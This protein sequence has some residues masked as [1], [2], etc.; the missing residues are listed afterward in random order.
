MTAQRTPGLVRG[1]SSGA[2]AYL[3]WG[4]F[5]IIITALSFANAWEVIA[6]RVIFGFVFGVIFVLA[7][8]NGREIFQALKSRKTFLLIIVST[9]MIYINWSVYV[10]A[11][12]TKHTVDASLGYF[13]NPLFTI[14]IA[15]LFLKE[16]LSRLQVVAVA[17][18]LV[19]VSILTVNYGAPPWLA[20]ALAASFSIYGYAKNQLSGSISSLNGYVVESGILVPV[21]GLQLIILAGQPGS[22]LS[23]G[24]A[25]LWETLGLVGF[26][27]LTAI[28]LILFGEAAKHLPLSWVGL[29]QYLTPTLQFIVAVLILGEPMSLP[30]WIGF[31]FVWIALFVLTIDASRK[32]KSRT[33]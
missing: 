27:F 10:F 23:F 32:F 8:R 31:A 30:R 15:V 26:G 9:V 1:F 2:A 6:W 5:P 13:I 19:S 16:R 18:A 11:V 24:S 14:L 22:Q 29:M 7:L 3:I 4:S 12:A 17:L 21:A 20:L 25:G 28:P 33:R